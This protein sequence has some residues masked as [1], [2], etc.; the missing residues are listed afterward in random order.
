MTAEKTFDETIHPQM[1]S[2]SQIRIDMAA[3][4]L[5]YHRYPINHNPALMLLTSK[6]LQLW[7]SQRG[8]YL[9]RA[10]PSVSLTTGL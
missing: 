9:R 7:S 3:Q 6:N 1:L 10:E 4:L 5:K 2:M 8:R